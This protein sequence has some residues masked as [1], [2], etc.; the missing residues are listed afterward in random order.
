MDDGRANLVEVLKG[1]DNLHDNRAP[2]LLTHQLILLQVE[3]K[4]I[5]FTVLQ[6]CAEPVRC[7]HNTSMLGMILCDSSPRGNHSAS[8]LHTHRSAL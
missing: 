5:A 2:L 7:E 6:H 1:V 4:V 8:S 3:V